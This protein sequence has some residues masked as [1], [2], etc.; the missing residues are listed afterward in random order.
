MGET[1]PPPAPHAP[2]T[3]I[4]HHHP[5]PPPGSDITTPKWVRHHHSLPPPPRVRHHHPCLPPPPPGSDITTPASPPPPPPPPY[6]HYGLYA[7][8]RYASYWNA[9]LSTH[10]LAS[11]RVQCDR[12]L[13]YLY[14]YFILIFILF[15]YFSY[16]T[17]FLLSTTAIFSI[18]SEAAV[19]LER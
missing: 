16:S 9:I 7:G 4:R 19:A 15:P 6:G 12:A 3:W 13:M 1:S 5:P 17:R 14:T 2:L 11:L 8:G 10:V 18:C